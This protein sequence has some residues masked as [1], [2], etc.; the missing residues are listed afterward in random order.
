[1][2]RPSLGAALLAFTATALAGC[3]LA[4][5]FA[6]KAPDPSGLVEWT[7]K[8]AVPIVKAADIGAPPGGIPASD[9]PDGKGVR[10]PRQSQSQPTMN[11]YFVPASAL[12]AQLDSDLRAAIFPGGTATVKATSDP[13]GTPVKVP[14]ADLERLDLVMMVVPG[15]G[16][17][18]ADGHACDAVA[19]T[20]LAAK[21]RGP[22][23]GKGSRRI[24]IYTPELIDMRKMFKSHGIDP[25]EICGFDPDVDRVPQQIASGC[26]AMAM[27]RFAFEQ[28]FAIGAGFS[29][30]TTAAL[31]LEL[32]GAIAEP[33][34]KDGVLRGDYIVDSTSF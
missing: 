7:V 10:M 24:V 28:D 4:D 5:W 14:V 33:P 13:A 22:V 12:S 26:S 27:A 34:Y 31:E 19:L 6:K 2:I 1:M 29:P 18:G 23:I 30:L 21:M 8:N 11:L 25:K 15:S 3:S 20:F 9:T 17:C 16:H 32:R